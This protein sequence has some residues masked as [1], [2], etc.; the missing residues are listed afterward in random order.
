MDSKMT[1]P[2]L[3]PSFQE[4]HLVLALGRRLARLLVRH[5]HPFLACFLMKYDEIRA[6]ESETMQ[7]TS[8]WSLEVSREDQCIS[9][10]LKPR[11]SLQVSIGFGLNLLPRQGVSLGS[12]KEQ[13]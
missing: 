10:T 4:P 3:R 11:S 13:E 7:S 9:P 2:G 1:W 6:G 5:R 8:I 12:R